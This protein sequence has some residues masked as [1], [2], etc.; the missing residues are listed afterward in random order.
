MKAKIFTA[1]FL[2]IIILFSCKSQAN[3]LYIPVPDEEYFIFDNAIGIDIGDIY[4]TRDGGESIYLPEWFRAFLYGGVEAVEGFFYYS[5]K[6]IFISVNQGDNFAALKRWADN[7]SELQDFPMLA[8]ARI[9]KKIIKSSS[10]YPDDEYGLFFERFIKY[11]YNAE[12]P[13][14]LKEDTYWIKLNEDNENT[15]ESAGAAE[16]YM[17]FILISIDKHVMQPIID[18]MAAQAA[19]DTAPA[20]AQAAAVSRLR[21]NFFEGF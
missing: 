9:E 10:L 18:N 8:A 5:D 1:G 14:A 7:F 16:G 12:Y 2:L 19:A 13:G 4:E 17:F 11:A 21:Q 6:Y 15:D 20:G 3:N